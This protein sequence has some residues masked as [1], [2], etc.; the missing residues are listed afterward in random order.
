MCVCGGLLSTGI[1]HGS[2][3]ESGACYRFISPNQ[4]STKETQGVINSYID[5]L[6]DNIF[7][8]WISNETSG[9]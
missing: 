2:F 3:P 6:V 7:F 9:L 4:V 5:D 8:F 1:Y